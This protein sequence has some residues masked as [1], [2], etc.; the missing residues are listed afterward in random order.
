[1]K[2]MRSIKRIFTEAKDNDQTRLLFDFIFS[3]IKFKCLLLIEKRVLMILNINASICHSLVFDEDGNYDPYSPTDFYF[4]V[5]YEIK[6]LYNNNKINLLWDKLDD[7]LLDL[8][9]SKCSEIDRNDIIDIVGKLKT[10]DKKYDPE[11]NKPYFK[12]WVRN[13]V[14]DVEDINIKKTERCFGIEIA[15]YCKSNNVSSRW[16]STMQNESLSFLKNNEELENDIK[17]IL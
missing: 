2:L 14:R 10:I 6:T 4:S 13:V 1:M 15:N 12:C 7:F 16:K 9:V 3:K 8:N 5:L 17:K 11:G